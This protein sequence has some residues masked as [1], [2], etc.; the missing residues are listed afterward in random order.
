MG[1]LP[2]CKLLYFVVYDIMTLIYSVL[3][4]VQKKY[5]DIFVF[6]GIQIAH[7]YAY[8]MLMLMHKLTAQNP[9]GSR[10]HCALEAAQMR[11][12]EPRKSPLRCGNQP[13][14]LCLRLHPSIYD[15]E[16]MVPDPCRTVASPFSVPITALID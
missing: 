11:G 3:F 1:Q 12:Q 2:P 6:Y 9:R 8:Y 15:R 7:A 13:M 10:R 16:Y 5:T 14:R 4:L